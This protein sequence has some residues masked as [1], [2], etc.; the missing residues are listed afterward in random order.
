MRANKIAKVNLEHNC[1]FDLTPERFLKEY[2]EVKNKI[3]EWVFKNYDSKVA[4]RGRM[5]PD[6]H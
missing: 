1:F 6:G 5:R 3:C 2:C 4:V